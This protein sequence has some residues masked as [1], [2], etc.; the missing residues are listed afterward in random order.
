MHER[1]AKAE[2]RVLER[3]AAAGRRTR[4]R[5]RFGSGVCGR[6][7]RSTGGQPNS[8]GNSLSQERSMRS[9]RAAVGARA[10][11][12]PGP[13]VGGV[14]FFSKRSFGGGTVGLKYKI[15]RP[16]DGFEDHTP[17]TRAEK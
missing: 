14:F 10:R 11:Q 15:L 9:R 8:G 12:P 13:G 16:R 7:D 4:R 2:P 5:D 1:P 6:L 3:I 17:K